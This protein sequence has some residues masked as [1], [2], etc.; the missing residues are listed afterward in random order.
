ME[1]AVV[2]M[3][4]AWARRLVSRRWAPAQLAVLVFWVWRL[5]RNM[6]SLLATPVSLPDSCSSQPTRRAVKPLLRVPAMPTRGM[7]PAPVPSSVRGNRWSAMAMPTGRGARS[8]EHTSE[9][10]SPCN[11]V[12][13]LLLEKKKKNDRPYCRALA[14]LAE[15]GCPA[16]S[17][18]VRWGVVVSRIA[19]LR[20]SHLVEA[21][22][23]AHPVV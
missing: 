19:V 11:L 17:H 3:T 10:Q 22:V 14:V 6:P 20:P 9:L 18:G 4:A 8:E 16:G 12:C 5:D 2:W 7:R 13:R 23:R 1:R 15:H 21:I